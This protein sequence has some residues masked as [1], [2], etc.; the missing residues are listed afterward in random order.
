MINDDLFLLLVDIDN[1]KNAC[2]IFF[3]A[4]IMQ[5]NCLDYLLKKKRKEPIILPHF[6]KVLPKVCEVFGY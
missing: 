6:H 2:Q 5:T 3:F 4:K 1:K